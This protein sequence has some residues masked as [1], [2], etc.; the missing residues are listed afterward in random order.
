MVEVS[1]C[2][3]TRGRPAGL[4]TL[5]ASLLNQRGAPNFDV[6]VIDNDPAGSARAVVESFAGR[7]QTTYDIEP[8]PG[9]SSAR[10]RSVAISQAPLL[11]FIDDD[12]RAQPGWLAAL[13]EKMADPAVAAA[14]GAVTFE[15]DEG[16][17][18]Y[19]RRCRLFRG[20]EF[21]DG[22]TLKWWGAW[23]GNSIIRRSALPNP[24]FEASLNLVGGEDSHLFDDMIA[25]GA[26]IVAARRAIT[27]E[28]RSAART[29]L[30]DLL[31]R[32]LRGGATDLEIEW[33]K[34]RRRLRARLRYGVQSIVLGSIHLALGIVCWIP[35]RAFALGQLM[36]AANWCGRLGRL[37]GWRYREYRITR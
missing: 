8:V 26:R 18:L 11:A 19:R 2:V 14:I 9:V 32:S 20:L 25:G 3:A 21:A 24:P 15:F 30:I 6:V 28:H 17:P 36:D 16:V 37:F 13:H 23:I 10:N 4:E 1:V 35:A 34:R 7:L 29:R 27:V 5:L 31:G 22:E 33:L 12:E